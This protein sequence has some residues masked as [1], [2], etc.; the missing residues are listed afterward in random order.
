MREVSQE[1]RIYGCVAALRTESRRF[2]RDRTM[3]GNTRG[4]VIHLVERR[5][6]TAKERD[7][8][9]GLELEESMLQ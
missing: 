8:S 4:A 5:M 7:C 2:V 6:R 3:M 9:D 1:A